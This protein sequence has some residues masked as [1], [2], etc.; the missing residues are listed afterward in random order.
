M[1]M[2]DLLLAPH[3]RSTQRQFAG[4]ALRGS[5]LASCVLM[6][7][8]LRHALMGGQQLL[9]I[10]RRVSSVLYLGLSLHKYS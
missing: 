6:Y 1:I 5:L 7:V 2:Y 3:Y 4:L 8:S 9:T 10:F